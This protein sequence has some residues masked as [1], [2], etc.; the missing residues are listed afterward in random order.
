MGTR[1]RKRKER[2]KEK[3]ITI[4]KSPTQKDV[5]REENC[6]GGG[7]EGGTNHRKKKARERERKER[8]RKEK[9]GNGLEPPPRKESFEKKIRNGR[10]A[11]SQRKERK[12]RKRKENEM[13]LSRRKSEEY[14]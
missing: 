3:K 2:K 14:Y 6:I 13:K 12:E 1:G 8:K 10:K 4:I 9:Q 11:P 5:C 7:E